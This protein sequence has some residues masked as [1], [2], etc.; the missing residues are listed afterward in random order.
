MKIL[1]IEYYFTPNPKQFNK[2]C[3]HCNQ[4][5]ICNLLLIYNLFT[6]LLHKKMFIFQRSKKKS[7][8]FKKNYNDTTKLYM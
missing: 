4:R 2:T 6:K 3:R 5:L 7:N 1:L 8:K